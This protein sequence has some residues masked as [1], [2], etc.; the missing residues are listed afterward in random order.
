M[1]SKSGTVKS[2]KL[3]GRVSVDPTEAFFVPLDDRP[4][5][6]SATLHTGGPWAAELQHAGPPTALLARELLRVAPPDKF[7]ARLTFELLGPIPVADVEVSAAIERPGRSVDLVTATMSAG[8][9][10]VIRATAWFVVPSPIAVESD[11]APPPLPA[12]DAR[13]PQPWGRSGYVSAMRWRFTHGG[14]EQPGPATVWGSMRLPLIAGEHPD[15]LTRLLTL[16]DSASGVSAVFDMR[17][18]LF[19]NPELTVHL[20]RLPEGEWIGLDAETL[21]SSGGAGLA[22]ATIFDRRGAVGRSAQSLLVRPR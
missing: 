4:G 6:F 7:A 16:V 15:P 13:P 18:W 1:K 2:S 22:T 8:G 3:N 11:F 5:R 20:H 12:R 10:E 17:E 9:R 19:I 21:I 14:F